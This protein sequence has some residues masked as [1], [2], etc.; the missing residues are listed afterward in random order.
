MFLYT[1]KEIP[2]SMEDVPTLEDVD[3]WLYLRGIKIPDINSDVG[4][5]IGTN[6]PLASEPWE[7]VHSQDDGPHAAK[8]LLGWAVRGLLRSN[9]ENIH[10]TQDAS[11]NRCNVCGDKRLEMQVEN[12]IDKTLTSALSMTDLIMWLKIAYS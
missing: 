9:T 12:Y 7:V 6:A 3:R 2:V 1:R 8:T 5:L 10:Q 11:V 4:L